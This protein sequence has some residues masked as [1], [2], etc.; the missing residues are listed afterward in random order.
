MQQKNSGFMDKVAGFVAGKGFYIILALC[1]AA[2]GVSGYVLFFT[3]NEEAMEEPLPIVNEEPSVTT[4]VALPEEDVQVPADAPEE[5]EAD[6]TA[7]TEPEEEQPAS[8][9]EEVPVAAAPVAESFISP[10]QNGKVLRGFSG[11]ELVADETMGDWRGHHGVDIACENG[12]QVCAIGD[13]KVVKVFHDQQTGYCITI[14]HGNGVV[15]TVRGLMENATVKEGD[16]V[17]MGAVIGGGG[18][19]MAVE[20]KMEPHIHLEVTKDEELIDPATLIS[21]I[22]S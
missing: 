20:S 14:D 17:K 16:T 19:T 8:Q 21:Q 1:A 10:V 3:G 22:Q 9:Q 5:E 7:E 4:P 12:G 11:D 18:N 13:G 6:Q 15:S 2:I